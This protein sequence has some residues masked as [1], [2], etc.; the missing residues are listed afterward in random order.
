MKYSSL[1]EEYTYKVFHLRL[2]NE[3]TN[4]IRLKYRPQ[5]FKTSMRNESTCKVL[6]RRI[7]YKF[8]AIAMVK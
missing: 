8:R 3:C 5:I 4:I 1:R 2:Q 6:N 7:Q